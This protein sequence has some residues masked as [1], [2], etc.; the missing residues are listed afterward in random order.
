MDLSI[1][2]CKKAIDGGLDGEVPLR[3]VPVQVVVPGDDS[4][5]RQLWVPEG[6]VL[7]D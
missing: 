5:G 3:Q 7:P 6:Q 1:A 4:A 2:I